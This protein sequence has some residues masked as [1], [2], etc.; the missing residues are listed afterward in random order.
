MDFFHIS[1][2]QIIVPIIVPLSKLVS[3]NNIVQKVTWS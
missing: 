2:V 3:G 1:D